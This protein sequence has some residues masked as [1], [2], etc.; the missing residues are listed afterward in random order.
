MQL[1]GAE[2]ICECLIEQGV[3]T[4]FGYPGGAALNTYD[5]L[6]KY[7]DRINHVLTAH[8]QG[9]S[10]AADGYARA[11]GK[12]GVVM[13]TSGPGATNIVTGLATAHIDSIPIVAITGN[14]TT[15]Q[16]GRDSFQEVDIVDI[17]KPVTKASY[18]VENVEDLA[19]T[20]RKAFALANE[21]RKGPV[22]VDVPK[23]VTA[24]K[25]EFTPKAP[26]KRESVQVTDKASVIKA[27]ELIKNSKKPII[28]AGGGIISSNTSAEFKRFAELIDAPVCCSLMGLGCI[29]A[30]HRLN[31]GN[32]GMHGGYETGM[33]TAQCDLIIACGARFSDRVAGDRERF[34]EQANIIHLDID[35]KEIGKNVAVDSYVIGD[36]ENILNELCENLNQQ[37]HSQWI[38]QLQDWKNEKS[39]A[40][41][42][43]D[44][45]PHPQSVIDAVNE[46]KK[47]ED[48]VATDVG[49][50]Q[51]WIAQYAKIEA[52]RTLLTSGGMG[53]MGFGMGAAIGAQTAFPNR[54]V[55]LFT[56]DGS[57]HMNLNEL[58]TMKSYNLPVVVIV[59]NNTVLG[60]V[61]QWQ[62]L[63]YGNRFSQ[64][65]PKRATDFVKLANAFGIEGMRINTADEIK[66]VL[67][68]AFA[69][70]APVV[71]DCKI[72][73]D[74]NVLPMIPPG[75]TV[76]DM[77][78]E[79]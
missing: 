35:K 46:I 26:E 10:H 62:K 66:P 29:P 22:L 42:V 30:S 47:P 43:N 13:T 27:A 53:T 50:H 8:E 69:L 70:N 76:D 38:K 3:D 58:V 75:K 72:S 67:E 64:T 71:V 1:T 12:T 37:D 41:A 79:M 32:I 18:L 52:P 16:L 5:A 74:E 2:I 15:D 7:S 68:K 65:D 54:R 21:G 20:I 49:Q 45:I 36:M 17:V 61:R 78:T 51:M 57:F 40:K 39:A 25:C 59:M 14:V 33:A 24:N 48:I 77:I 28:Y 23:D 31:M 9:A 63:F 19:D 56:G 11:T 73:P 55:V 60:M 34:G 4:V 6:Y 44:N